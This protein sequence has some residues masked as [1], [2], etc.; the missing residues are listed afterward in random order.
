M[1]LKKIKYEL[2]DRDYG[3]LAILIVF[4]ITLLTVVFILLGD[5][6]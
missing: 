6:R 3:T 2:F 4:L 1:N 5:A